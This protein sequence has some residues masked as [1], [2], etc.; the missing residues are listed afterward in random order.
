MKTNETYIDLKACFKFADYQPLSMKHFLLIILL[1]FSGFAVD[2]Q[3]DYQIDGA[4]NVKMNYKPF[5]HDFQTQALSWSGLASQCLDNPKYGNWFALKLKSDKVKFIVHS[6]GKMGDIENPVLY[7]GEVKSTSRVKKMEEVTCLK[8]KGSEGKFALSAS[9]LDPKSEYF[10]L[11]TADREGAFYAIETT[12]KFESPATTEAFEKESKETHSIFGRILNQAGDA[13][14]NVEVSLLDEGKN[15]LKTVKTDYRGVFKFES[16]PPDE[17]YLTLIEQEDTELNIEMF[18]IDQNGKI[19][20]RAT[21]IGDQLYA[22]GANTDGFE[23]MKLLTEDDCQHLLSPGKVGM[24]G[25]V[26]DKRTFLFA[27][28]GIEVE[29]YDNQKVLLASSETNSKGMFSFLNLES[30]SYDV[31]VKCD[32]N[33]EFAEVVIIDDLGVPNACASSDKMNDEGFFTFEPLPA[34][35]IKLKRLEVQDVEMKLPS[36]FGHMAE[37]QP[38]VLRSILFESGSAELLPSSYSELDDLVNELSE[39]GLKIEVSGHTDDRGVAS[40]NIILSESRAKSVVNYLEKKG[41][42]RSRMTF[43]G[44]GSSKPV[45]PNNTDEG[46]AMNRR[47]EFVVVD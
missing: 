25:K 28:E 16:L 9:G 20:N 17:V 5:P 38:I 12:D 44:Y 32:P 47:V 3:I 13:Q 46:R 4:R 22:F 2:A 10:L 41:I 15:K 33:N 1:F 26:V 36:D 11:V 18:L 8:H 45:A 39:N 23:M 40:T 6:G 42:D 43:K 34:D 21:R 27:Q 24:V 19:Q 30:Q 31:K 7:L 35:I 14:K 37:K 29:L